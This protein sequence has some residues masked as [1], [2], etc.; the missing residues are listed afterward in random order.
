M[1]TLFRVLLALVCGTI[2]PNLGLLE[3]G[4]IHD[5]QIKMASEKPTP[6]KKPENQPA[7]DNAGQ[8]SA[9]GKT[10][11]AACRPCHSC[12]SGNAHLE[13]K[14]FRLTRQAGPP[15]CI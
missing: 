9:A 14:S 4:M 2:A 10:F 7:R 12:H 5:E 1:R 15:D 13:C 11:Q 6:L 8:G 3:P